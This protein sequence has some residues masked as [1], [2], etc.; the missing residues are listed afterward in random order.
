MQLFCPNCHCNH[1]W[2]LEYG[3]FFP[4]LWLIVTWYDFINKCHITLLVLVS[5]VAC[6]R[7]EPC[8]GKPMYTPGLSI[9]VWRWLYN[10][11][12]TWMDNVKY[13]FRII[14]WTVP[15]GKLG[16]LW[17]PQSEDTFFLLINTVL[18]YRPS[19]AVYFAFELFPSG[20]L[21]YKTAERR[22]IN[23]I[24]EIGF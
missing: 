20:P 18:S 17:G 19:T 14:I 22:P 23:S 24:S 6:L 13:I 16:V 8:T 10:S 21:I 9:A 2:F 11:W 3:A 7:R 15:L 5:A 12:V 4:V 1:G